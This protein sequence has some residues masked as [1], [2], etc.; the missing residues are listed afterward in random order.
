MINFKNEIYD[1]EIIIGNKRN[2]NIN[3]IWKGL[4]L[5]TYGINT[6]Q[7]RSE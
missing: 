3:E 7:N 6:Q 1:F 4:S 5:S 2:R